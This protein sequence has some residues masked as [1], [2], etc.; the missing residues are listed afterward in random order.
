MGGVAIAFMYKAFSSKGNI[1][2]KRVFQSIKENKDIPFVMIPLIFISTLITHMFGGSAGREGAALQ[3][4]GSMGYN[5]AKKLKYDNEKAVLMVSAGMSSVF[6]ALFGVPFAATI[7]SLEVTK[8]KGMFTC[9]NIF[10]GLI[11]SVIAFVVAQFLGVAPVRF[12]LPEISL[13]HTDIILKSA[14]LAVLCAGVC[15]IFATAIHKSE[16]YMKKYMANCYLRA[17]IGGLIIV[18]LSIALKTTDYNGAGMGVIENAI[19]G[20]ALNSAFIMKIIFT[21]ITIGA[22]FKG[23]EIVPTFFIGATFGCAISAFIGFNAPL[24]ASLGLVALFAGMT[25]CPLTSLFLAVEIFGIKGIVLFCM[26]IVIT[27]VFSGRFGLY[28]NI[29]KKGKLWI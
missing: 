27:Y 2:I 25:K 23:G 16:V 7:F 21:A 1:D 18:L 20:Q 11:S 8:K 5:L 26:V 29:N 9:S 22:G 19:S 24:G 13:Y 17:V 28:D 15:I 14:L 4:G 12:S 10:T 3:L 6:A